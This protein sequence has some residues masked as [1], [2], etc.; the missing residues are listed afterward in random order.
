MPTGYR[1]RLIQ[2][3][4]TASHVQRISGILVALTRQMLSVLITLEWRLA[5]QEPTLGYTH[6]RL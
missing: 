5:T 1:L 4:L 6:A 3:I 2:T